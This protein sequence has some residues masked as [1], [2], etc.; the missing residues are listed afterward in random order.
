M[1]LRPARF[2]A[3]GLIRLFKWE[4]YYQFVLNRQGGGFELADKAT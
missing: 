1:I 3:E 2:S 4:I